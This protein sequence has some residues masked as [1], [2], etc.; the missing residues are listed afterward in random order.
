MFKYNIYFYFT[1]KVYWRKRKHF[2]FCD[3]YFKMSYLL[4]TIYKLKCPM[5]NKY[6]L[7]RKLFLS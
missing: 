5:K 1:N 6:Y 7:L 3:L 4:Y 2:S